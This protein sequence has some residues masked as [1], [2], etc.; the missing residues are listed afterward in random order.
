MNVFDMEASRMFHLHVIRAFL[1]GVCDSAGVCKMQST[2]Q[3]PEAKNAIGITTHEAH[4][5]RK[6]A[7]DVEKQQDS[8]K[9]QE[10]SL[11]K[12]ALPK[13]MNTRRHF[14]FTL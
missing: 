2:S 3:I 8:E 14:F 7:H 6:I 5:G 10:I 12:Q 4:A 13:A 11:P 9:T 1:A